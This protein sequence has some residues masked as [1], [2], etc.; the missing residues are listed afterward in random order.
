MG[1]DWSHIE[2]WSWKTG[3]GTGHGHH[4]IDIGIWYQVRTT[5]G[6]CKGSDGI[7]DFVHINMWKTWV[8]GDIRWVIVPKARINIFGNCVRKK[9]NLIGIISGMLL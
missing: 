2:H 9:R 8:G 3:T 4:K 1:D 7:R 6:W 5:H